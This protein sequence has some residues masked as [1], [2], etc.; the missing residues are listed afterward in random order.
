MNN[1]QLIDSGF[2]T[3]LRQSA[4]GATSI[5]C[6]GLDPVIEALPKEYARKGI[7]GFVSFMEKV[8]SQMVLKGLS[9]GMF[10]PNLAW[11]QDFD[12]PFDEKQF[13]GSKALVDMMKLAKAYFPYIPINTDYKNGDI[14]TSSTKWA[15]YGFNRWC[16]DA[17]TVHTYMG[18]DSISPFT[19]YCNNEKR[20]GAYLLV[21]TGIIYNYRGLI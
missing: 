12:N 9:P 14:G 16:A 2:L 8:L 20:K 7:N 1:E 6:F 18:S 10:K 19:D 3:Q 4:K 15:S 13:T 11:W 5:I 21:K 17:V